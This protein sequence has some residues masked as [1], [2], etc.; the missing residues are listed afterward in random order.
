MNRLLIG[1]VVMILS[2]SYHDSRLK[3]FNSKLNTDKANEL[4]GLV[5]HFNVYLSELYPDLGDFDSRFTKLLADLE[6]N[7][8]NVSGNHVLTDSVSKSVVDAYR[9][10]GLDKELWIKQSEFDSISKNLAS[11]QNEQVEE[12]VIEENIID[13]LALADTFEL[14]H[15]N[16]YSGYHTGLS[17]FVNDEFIK[18]YLDAR[19]KMGDLTL[20]VMI[21]AF[22]AWSDRVD[23]NDPILKRIVT[24]EVFVPIAYQSMKD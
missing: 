19:E 24:M 2:C 16:I 20:S 14:Y 13:S 22:I 7:R 5:G 4:T 21:G 23:Y 11:E 17:Q 1:F 15:T 12:L 6:K 9:L 3:I 10:S 18:E 8:Y